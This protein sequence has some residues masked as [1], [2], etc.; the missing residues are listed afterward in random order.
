M[1][2]QEDVLMTCPYCGKVI[3][4]TGL[5]DMTSIYCSKCSRLLE[6]S[7][8][9]NVYTVKEAKVDYIAAQLS[10]D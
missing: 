2:K 7:Y 8:R 4:R 3:G 5:T 9:N 6:I 10:A 1:K